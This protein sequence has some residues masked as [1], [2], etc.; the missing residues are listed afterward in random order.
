MQPSVPAAVGPMPITW[1]K[2]DDDYITFRFWHVR[3][4]D[5]SPDA[6]ALTQVVPSAAATSRARDNK[7]TGS[8]RE[9]ED[10]RTS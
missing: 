5:Q 10:P 8:C 3:M 2:T 4:S 1:N 9:G 7:K 6:V